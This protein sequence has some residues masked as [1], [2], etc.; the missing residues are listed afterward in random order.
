MHAPILDDEMHAMRGGD[1]HH[2]YAARLARLWS[3]TA[4]DAQA[5]SVHVEAAGSMFLVLEGSIDL[6]CLQGPSLVRTHTLRV[7]AG[8]LLFGF[9]PFALPNEEPASFLAVPTLGTQWVEVSRTTARK[10]DLASEFDQR[11]RYA[12]VE[13]I[14]RPLLEACGEAPPPLE[15]RAL[16]SPGE[17]IAVTA[18]EAVRGVGPELTWIDYE[19]GSL[20]QSGGGASLAGRRNGPRPARTAV[21]VGES[22][23]WR[24][25]HDGD[26]H[27]LSTEEWLARS[28]WLDELAELQDDTLRA[29][30]HRRRDD[31]AKRR[32]RIGG[33]ER[34]R[35]RE[36]RQSIDRLTGVLE[37]P[38]ESAVDPSQTVLAQAAELVCRREGF[39]LGLGEAASQ[40][41]GN[42]VDGI[43]PLAEAAGCFVRPVTL[44]DR[45]WRS[46]GRPLLGFRGE[47]HTPCALLPRGQSGNYELV[48]PAAENR[49]VVDDAVAGTVA[50]RAYEFQRPFP[51][52]AMGVVD[53]AR[54]A[55]RGTGAD[56]WT[57]IGT[58]CAVGLLALALPIA[59]GWVIDP[60]IPQHEMGNLLVLTVALLFAGVGSTAFSLVQAIAFV[61]LRGA[62]GNT[63]QMAVWDRL[64][65]LPVSFFR[66]FAVGDLVSRALGM[67]QIK[68]LFAQA[69]S[70]SALHAV[71]SLLSLTL[72]V[73]YSWRLSLVVLG[74]VFLYAL[75][76]LPVARGTLAATRALMDVSGRLQGLA[77]Q[78]L[79]ALLKLRVAGAEEG[80]FAVWSERYSELLSLFFRVRRYQVLLALAQS[81][82]LILALFA[83]L[84]FLSWHAGAT[85]DFFRTAST[86]N[87]ILG[88]RTHEALMPAGRFVSFHVAMGQFLA[89]AFGL[90]SVAT[91][92]VGAVPLLRRLS[93]LLDAR[94]E[95]SDA[96]TAV[97][98]R[99]E[100]EFTSVDYRYHPD[101]PLV[102]E[103]LSFRAA[104]GSLTALV[105]PSGGGKSTL[106]RLL[107]GF[108]VPEAGSVFVDGHDLRLMNAKALR[109]QLGV[110]IQDSQ[111][112][113]TT[114]LE[115]IRA[116]TAA[117]LEDVWEAARLAGIADDIEAMPMGMYTSLNE[118]AATL[119]GGQ[120]QR[121][122][123]AR[124]LVRRPRILVFDEATSAL[125]NQ[126]QARVSANIASLNATRIVIAHRL[127]T[128]LQA[129]RIYFIDEGR[130][131][132]E[133]TYEELLERR[134]RFWEMAERQ[135]LSPQ[136]VRVAQRREGRP[137]GQAAPVGLPKA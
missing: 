131:V 41:F 95:P 87:E 76:A 80:A 115:A 105:G 49:V 99:G 68:R 24:V 15:C 85:L 125:D 101:E 14:V 9:E 1:R 81:M 75:V 86:W 119:S 69:V 38:V 127:S 11:E 123:I 112:L 102:L 100:I 132:E 73:Y 113:A 77:F 47:E 63:A 89:G 124:A 60:V 94:P 17:S 29:V 118:R 120:R 30:V 128:V 97:I 78:L 36:L 107:L 25:V 83:V 56:A 58:L 27:P 33:K 109:R 2:P 82:A 71:A 4:L 134:G 51:G 93:P 16:A 43:R 137:S 110:V 5:K 6:F 59:T 20:E 42:D 84:A 136:S 35:A 114:V 65:K 79:G 45:W 44:P 72:M 103:G 19:R 126:T 122:M 37:R 26:L 34:H 12:V 62:M 61:R 23:W 111:V 28:T 32:A 57:V 50:P 135:R 22:V 116:S 117:S 48:D 21:P 52:G 40:R 3:G 64:L 104:P 129:D 13:A 106:V 10:I 7:D 96:T 90:T 55:A 67:D 121:L 92:L 70:E 66:Q 88:T 8:G 53:L 54:F 31:D 130:V 91:Q 18:G 46:P 39:A 74:V 98:E 133:G 108:D